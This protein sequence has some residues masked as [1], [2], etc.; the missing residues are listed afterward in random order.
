MKTSLGQVAIATTLAWALAQGV[1]ACAD[2]DSEDPAPGGESSEQDASPDTDDAASCRRDDAVRRDAGVADASGDAADAD[3]D[4]GNPMCTTEGWC[5]TDA[6]ASDWLNGVYNLATG[7]PGPSASKATC[8][9]TTA[10]TGRCH[11]AH[12]Q[13]SNLG[14]HRSRSDRYVGR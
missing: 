4:A 14:H 5:V 13:R 6:P 7:Q 10:R 3:V 2:S 9:A 8:C 1:L 12:G 11:R